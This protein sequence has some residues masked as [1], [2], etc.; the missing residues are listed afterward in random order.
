MITQEMLDKLET[1]IMEEVEK[2][3][4]NE[5]SYWKENMTKVMTLKSVG[6]LSFGYL[7]IRFGAYTILALAHIHRRYYLQY[8]LLFP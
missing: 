5:S 6:V 7:L 8:I 4:D 2:M 3:T 1:K